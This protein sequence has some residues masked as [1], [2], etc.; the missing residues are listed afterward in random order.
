MPSRS[1]TN[2][3]ALFTHL[4]VVTIELQQ[5]FKPWGFHHQFLTHLVLQMNAE[6][7]A[8]LTWFVNEV[9]DIEMCMDYLPPPGRFE[10]FN[11]SAISPHNILLGK[12]FVL[13][14]LV[15]QFWWWLNCFGLGK[16]K[17]QLLLR[18]KIFSEVCHAGKWRKNSNFHNF[19]LEAPN[20]PYT[21][22]NQRLH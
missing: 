17:S 10:N 11:F 3:N 15:L 21:F 22:L 20:N 12:L 18:A 16:I 1:L 14:T 19:F 5:C 13:T 4:S 7:I 2:A 8:K 9:S 6:T